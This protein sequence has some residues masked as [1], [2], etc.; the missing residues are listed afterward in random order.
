MLV[1]QMIWSSTAV[2]VTTWGLAQLPALNTKS[3]GVPAPGP[4]FSRGPQVMV[5]VTGWVGEVSR[6]TL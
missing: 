4:K 1:S 3:M 5:M 6:A 2:T